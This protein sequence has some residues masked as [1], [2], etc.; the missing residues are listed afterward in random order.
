M[1]TVQIK[2]AELRK[3]KLFVATPMY[4]AKCDGP[5]TKSLIDLNTVCM[6]HGVQMRCHFLFNESLI[7][8]ARNYLADE[9]L[10]SDCTHL[11]FID[12]DIDFD[13]KYVIAMLA[14]DR[15]IIGGPYPKKTIA[16]EKIFDATRLGLV[17]N[18]QDFNQ[19][20]GDYVF[21]LVPG[22]KQIR[23]DEP[24]PVLEIGTGFMMIRRDVFTKF[25]AAYPEQ[26]F[27]PDHNRTAA[28]DGSREICAFFHDLIDPATKRFL[29]EDYMFCQWARK[30]GVEI[31]LCPWMELK[32]SGTF[33]FGG[34][35]AAL[36]KLSQKQATAGQAT[37]VV[38]S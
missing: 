7:T 15:E 38:K 22:T 29:S 27:K 33:V 28:F 30:I 23:I 34:S 37:A 17:N 21:N 9:F 36:A 26:M 35:M 14:L 12:S 19:F 24:A 20:V 1:A 32:H 13:P 10:R 8:R 31:W 2:A 6:Q 4:G 5:Y 3:R 18:P 25:Q 11:M 16:W